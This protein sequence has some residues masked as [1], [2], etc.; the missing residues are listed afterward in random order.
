M[1]PAFL[2]WEI[3]DYQLSFLLASKSTLEEDIFNFQKFQQSKRQFES[4]TYQ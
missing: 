2:S 4:F 3:F 1:V